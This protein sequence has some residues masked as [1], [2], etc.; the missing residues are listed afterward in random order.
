M[1]DAKGGKTSSESTYDE[2]TTRGGGRR[3]RIADPIR[4]S[5]ALGRIVERLGK[6]RSVNS[7]AK[8]YEVSQPQLTKLLNQRRSGMT[9][10]TFNE[11][12]W[13]AWCASAP[14]KDSRNFMKRQ[15]DLAFH[16]IE[17][18]AAFASWKESQELIDIRD[19]V[20]SS[21]AQAA[22]GAFYDEIFRLF[23]DYPGVLLGLDQEERQRLGKL[24]DN[25]KRLRRSLQRLTKVLTERN[26]IQHRW[27]L[28]F[29]RA[30]APLNLY[31][32]T[33]GIERC[34]QELDDEELASFVAFGL[35]RERILLDRPHERAR[36]Q[37]NELK[38]GEIK[39]RRE[40]REKAASTRPESDFVV[41][42]PDL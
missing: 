37:E 42:W 19:S 20:L 36:A 26:H 18:L 32:T 31:F 6:G 1:D 5:R 21:G 3:L 11:L 23:S 34:M 33:G 16:G 38:L 35:E 17:I 24:V 28:A 29:V 39:R 40:E 10:R 14:N 30:I 27:T 9:V 7:V 13:L 8:E 15:K 12:Q 25:N 4:L 22:L 41:L 2:S